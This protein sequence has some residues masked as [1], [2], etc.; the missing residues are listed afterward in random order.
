MKVLLLSGLFV[1]FASLPVR[2]D[3]WKDV[4][5]SIAWGLLRTNL[6]VNKTF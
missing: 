5:S 6:Y 1:L 4:G 2:A 3:V